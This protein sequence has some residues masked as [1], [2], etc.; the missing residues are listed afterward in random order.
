M[1][2][3]R[4]GLRSR[5][6][7]YNLLPVLVVGLF[8]TC[9]YI[10]NRYNQVEQNLIEKGTSIIEPL[11]L[12]IEGPLGEDR[13]DTVRKIVNYAHR[14]NSELVDTIAVFDLASNLFVT[15]KYVRDFSDLK[16]PFDNK[17]SPITSVHYHN[18]SII[19][20]T[21]IFSEVID[22]FDVARIIPGYSKI[23]ATDNPTRIV[24]Y[25][26]MKLNKTPA[27]MILYHDSVLSVFVILVGM[28]ISLIFAFNLIKEV[29]EPI[30]RMIRAI[31]YI[32]DGH[33]DTRITGSMHG[34]LERLRSG[35]NG[36]AQSIAEYHNEMQQ[37]IDQ[38]TADLRQTVEQIEIQNIELDLAKKRAQEAARVKTEFLANMSHELRTPLNGIIG[39]TKQLFKSK[40]T[41]T[42]YE[43]LSTIER[44]A[45]N[46]LNIINNILD[47]SKL[48]AGKLTFEKI[49]FSIRDT[50]DEV[51]M[52]TA[53]IAHEKDIDLSAKI[54]YAIPD[55][56][57]GDPL[58]LQQIL[59]NLVSNAIKFTESGAV[60]ITMLLINQLTSEDPNEIRVEIIVRDTGIGISPSQQQKIFQPFVQANNSISRTFGGT[61][62]GLVITQKIVS[63]MGGGISVKSQ[64]NKGSIF[65]TTIPLQKASLPSERN[66]TIVSLKDQNILLI[67][68]CEWARDSYSQMMR[69]WQMNVYVLASADSVKNIS[70]ENFFAIIYAVHARENIQD[71]KEKIE[72]INIEAPLIFFSNSHDSEFNASLKQLGAFDVLTKPINDERLLASFD[73]INNSNEQPEIKEEQAAIDKLNMKV[74]AVDDNPANLKLITML[75]AERVTVVDGCTS[76]EQSVNM[77]RINDYDLIFMDIQM[78]IMDGIT[79][80]GKIRED[81]NGKNQQTPI[82][83][84]TALAIPGER[85]RLM[86]LGMS[87]YISKPIDENV[88]GKLL[89]NSKN[90]EKFNHELEKAQEDLFLAEKQPQIRDAELA[91][92]H[93]S[94]K[95]ELAR[96]MLEMFM[97]SVVPTQDAISKANS[98][99]TDQLIK[100]VHKLAG[101]A[102]YSGMVKI[103][104]ICNIIE[105][106]LRGGSKL[107]DVEPE[108]YE[109]DDLLEM[110]KKQAPEWFKQLE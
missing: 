96:E 110:S 17:L 77:C 56:L 35:I 24:G 22:N 84:V 16:Q 3:K 65:T 29:V 41:P 78:P 6:I 79:A 101:G 103:Q 71:V 55:L 46:L 10:F 8:F 107:S 9:F 108:L 57:V 47:F 99:S 48:E 80:L 44:S 93:V 60:N 13:L 89:S 58:R 36:M 7:I 1:A 68:D 90:L 12:S 20:R 52:I 23:D 25:V 92:K 62:L 109:L 50:V 11:T 67:D 5:V 18:D 69:D 72:S 19:L 88:L 2:F 86:N 32:K 75:L 28:I 95:K 4:Y 15:S 74:L 94:G 42:Q 34:E 54:D 97:A 83:A 59:T 21:P 26:S 39:F 100:V 61:G 66:P 51:L 37:S 43:Y 104:K 31:A 49:P 33:L 53:P 87:E 81:R 91:L 82:V 38:A 64:V 27:L 85:E 105:A 73:R 106:N 40:L 30:K 70:V 98:L 14:N 45:K 63:L 76:G 102:A